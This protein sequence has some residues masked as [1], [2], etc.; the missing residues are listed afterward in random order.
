LKAP[1]SEIAVNI[2]A[3]R[4]AAGPETSIVKYSNIQQQFPNNSEIIPENKVKLKL[5]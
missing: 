4:P 1:K 2:I 5:F 3:V